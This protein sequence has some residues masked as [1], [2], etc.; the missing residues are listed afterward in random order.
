MFTGKMEI[1]SRSDMESFA[2][3]SGATVGRSVTKNTD[4]LVIGKRVGATKLKKAEKHG[5]KILTEEEFLG[6]ARND[7]DSLEDYIQGLVK[8]GFDITYSS[9]EGDG[10]QATFEVDYPEDAASVGEALLCHARVSEVVKKRMKMAQGI[11]YR[12]RTLKNLSKGF[13]PLVEGDESRGWSRS[14]DL[15]KFARNF[16]AI[17]DDA[18]ISGTVIVNDLKQC[19]EDLGVLAIHD[20]PLEES[21]IVVHVVGGAHKKSGRLQGFILERVWT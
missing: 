1:G 21:V 19:I 15:S 18:V 17:S 13:S 5:V 8:K 2:R 14:V 10:F 16:R 9:N 20:K 12:S 6:A 7:V 11:S 4:Y 3:S